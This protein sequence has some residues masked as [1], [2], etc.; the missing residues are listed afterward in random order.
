MIRPVSRR[1]GRLK[2]RSRKDP[3]VF[4]LKI[5]QRCLQENVPGGRS[6]GAD[7]SLAAGNKWKPVLERQCGDKSTAQAS[8]W[9]L[10]WHG[11]C[12]CVIVAGVRTNPCHYIQALRDPKR[13][14]SNQ[15]SRSTQDPF[16]PGSARLEL[17][18]ASAHLPRVVCYSRTRHLFLM[19]FCFAAEFL[20]PRK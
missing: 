15:D 18:H 2:W 8:L 19:F 4:G 12:W 13:G 14:Q 3:Q 20:A 7:G 6:W 1:R 10:I 5:T 11:E 16:E 9:A 17:W